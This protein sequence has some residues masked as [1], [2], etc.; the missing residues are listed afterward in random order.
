MSDDEDVYVLLW[1]VKSNTKP[2]K[3]CRILTLVADGT[4]IINKQKKITV[5]SRYYDKIALTEEKFN[6]IQSYH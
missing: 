4:Q 1:W 5:V 2:R 6:L 3:Y